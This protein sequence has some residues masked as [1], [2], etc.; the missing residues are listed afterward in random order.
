[1]F[2]ACYLFRKFRFFLIHLACQIGERSRKASKEIPLPTILTRFFQE[3][4]LKILCKKMLEK[5]DPDAAPTNLTQTNALKI[6]FRTST[7]SGALVQGDKAFLVQ[8][9]TFNFVVSFKFLTIL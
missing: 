7:C 2:A 8:S 1:M 3:F 5:T 6:K 4:G 9:V